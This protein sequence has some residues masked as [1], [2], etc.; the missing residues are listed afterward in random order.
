MCF[1]RYI[2]HFYI[3]AFYKFKAKYTREQACKSE[4]EDGE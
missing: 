1:V 3:H 4:E 2:C